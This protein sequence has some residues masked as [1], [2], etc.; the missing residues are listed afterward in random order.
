MKNLTYSV[1]NKLNKSGK[2]SDEPSNFGEI[3]NISIQNEVTNRG[4]ERLIAS[5]SDERFI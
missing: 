3:Y 2:K 4:N 1:N 5:V